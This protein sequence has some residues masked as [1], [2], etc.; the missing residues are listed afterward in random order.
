MAFKLQKKLGV[1]LRKKRGDLTLL[2][3]SKKLGIS[4]ASLHRMEQGSQNVTLN[5]LER[6]SDRLKCSVGQMLGE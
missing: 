5:T 3:F 1:F 4:D 2:Q 6:I